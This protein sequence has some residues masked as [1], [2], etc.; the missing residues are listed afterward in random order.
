MH[1]ITTPI[2]CA[3]I[4]LLL[5]L[6]AILGYL[7]ASHA[8]QVKW[9]W[10]IGNEPDFW[11]T[12]TKNYTQLGVD[13]VNLEKLIRANYSGLGSTVY[14]PSFGGLDAAYVAE[15]MQGI[16]GYTSGITGSSP[17][18]PLYNVTLISGVCGAGNCLCFIHLPPSCHRV[19]PLSQFR[20]ASLRSFPMH[21]HPHI[22]TS[23]VHSYPLAR[24][25]NIS[26]YLKAKAPVA[27][28]GRHLADVAATRNG[29]NKN[30]PLILE[31]TAGSFDGGCVSSAVWLTGVHGERGTLCRCDCHRR[32]HQTIQEAHLTVTANAAASHS[33]VLLCRRT[34]PTVLSTASSGLIP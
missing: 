33:I 30:T 4:P 10:S 7:N 13:S 20:V 22:V 16:G 8:G 23:A 14:G 21:S 5:L 26:S 9:A 11:P 3:H 19:N 25:C 28:M 27:D 1:F 29:I 15:Y 12:T 31:E 2:P 32:L 17:S 18:R 34:S 24:D 6:Q